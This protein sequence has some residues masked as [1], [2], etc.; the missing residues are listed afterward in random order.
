M[1][2]TASPTAE[3]S[4][5]RHAVLVVDDEPEIRSVFVEALVADGHDATAAAD[6][7]EALRMLHD[8]SQPCLV[9]ADM[10]MPGMNGH[11]LRSSVEN[12]PALCGVPVV[13]VSSYP[14]VV[15]AAT[16]PKPMDLSELG[17]LIDNRCAAYP[18]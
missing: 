8:G 2:R 14:A 18:G 1:R 7:I 4:D 5:H 3:Q 12:D 15:D 11:E 17:L 9:L 10:V 16:S 13:V 6:G